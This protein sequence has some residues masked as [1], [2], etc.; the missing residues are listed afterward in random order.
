MERV[1]I[2]LKEILLDDIQCIK[3][4]THYN[5]TLEINTKDRKVT[6]FSV[7]LVRQEES[8]KD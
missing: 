1:A 3:L 2:W 6:R 8:K 7:I 4:N 5:D